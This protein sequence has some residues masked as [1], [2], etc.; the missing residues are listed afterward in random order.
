MRFFF[1]NI[2]LLH[3]LLYLAVKFTWHYFEA[4][5]EISQRIYDYRSYTKI[6]LQFDFD[7]HLHLSGKL[8][9]A[10][11]NF[12]NSKYLLICIT[13]SSSE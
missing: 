13:E 1:I 8:G 12:L 10:N 2:G 9:T 4:Y 7:T 3:E 11:N 6:Q 5:P